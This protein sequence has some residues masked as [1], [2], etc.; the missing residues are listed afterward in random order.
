M[1]EG[2][3]SSRLSAV[4]G[5]DISGVNRHANTGAEGPAWVA[6]G[7]R[8]GRWL[9]FQAARESRSFCRRG[10]DGPGDPFYAT[11]CVQQSATVRRRGWC[12]R[13][14]GLARLTVVGSTRDEDIHTSR[15]L[16]VTT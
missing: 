16:F 6:G 8:L 7:V 15:L 4:R 9:P 10:S 14:Q 5:D 13:F 3:S 12:A 1:S 11:C 2:D